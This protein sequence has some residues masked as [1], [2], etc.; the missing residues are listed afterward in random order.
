MTEVALGRGV[1]LLAGPSGS[2]K[3]TVARAL[4]AQGVVEAHLSMGQLLRDLVAEAR[5]TPQVAAALNAEL[6][7][8]GGE[9]EPLREVAHSLATGQLIPDA[10][11]ER[12]IE[13]QLERQA[14]LRRGRWLLDGYPRRVEAARHLLRTLGAQDIPVLRVLN[15]ELGEA[16]QVARLRARGRADDTPEAIARRREVYEREVVPTI[17]FLRGALPPGTVRDVNAETPGFSPAQGERE[18]V[19]R[20]LAA[21]S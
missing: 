16:Q 20:A 3:G 11:T 4:L 2:G 10:W 14:T 8:L 5:R 17:A 21:L 18:L 7:T 6:R 1:V 12:L 19:R 9:G 15:L 13:R